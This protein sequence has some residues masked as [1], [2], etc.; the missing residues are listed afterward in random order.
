MRCSCAVNR[1]RPTLIDQSIN[2]TAAMSN[3]RDSPRTEAPSIVCKWH[4]LVPFY[5]TNIAFL[6][7]LTVCFKVILKNGT[8]ASR[9]GFNGG[10]RDKGRNREVPS[11][12][13]QVATLI[14]YDQG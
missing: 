7:D 8:K 10:T 5:R 3:T 12:A 14:T 4:V 2:R 11:E 6:R 9:Q 13:V 1:L